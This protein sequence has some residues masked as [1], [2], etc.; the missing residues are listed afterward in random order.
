MEKY[1]IYR[2]TKKNDPFSNFIN[3]IK[4]NILDLIFSLDGNFFEKIFRHHGSV[5]T[6]LES[7]SGCEWSYRLVMRKDE[8][9]AQSLATPAPLRFSTSE[10]N[11]CRRQ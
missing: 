1:A 10:M 8:R 2:L 5:F 7:C 9:F 6:A 11:V 4:G 3:T